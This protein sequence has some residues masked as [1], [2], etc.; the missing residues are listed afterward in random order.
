MDHLPEK[1]FE[2]PAN[3][4]DWAVYYR[5]LQTFR[6][7][8]VTWWRN[9]QRSDGQAGGGW[10]DDT[11]IFSR[12]FGDMPLDSNEDAMILFNK[13]FDGFEKTNYFKDGYC[14]IDPI[15]R[16]HNGDF[17]RERY[18]SLIYNIGDPR[19][20]VWAM[21]EAWHWN[22]PDKTP[23]NYG[24]GKGF[25]FGKD[26]ME[27]YWGGHIADKPYE[28]QDKA[29][30]VATLKKAALANDEVTLWRFTEAWCHSD[31]QSQYGAESLYNMLL[32]G[33]GSAPGRDKPDY[34]NRN[35][36]TVGIGWVKGG[37][38]QLGRLIEYSGDDGL[39]V[40][41]YSFDR[42]DREATA[43][44]YR[45][46]DGSYTV[47]LT[48]D[49]DGD[50]TF[51]KMLSERK[52][53]IRRFDTVSATVPPQ[54]LVRLSIKQIKA[55][56]VPASMPDLAVCGRYLA[57]NRD[58]L[59]AEIYNIGCAPSGKFTVTV[60]CPQGAVLKT[61]TV[62]SIPGSEDFVPKKATV[63]IPGLPPRSAYT[64]KIDSNDKV[65]EIFEGNNAATIMTGTF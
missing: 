32:G 39:V 55:A 13:V 53:D 4:P 50:G 57:L 54:T 36:L 12:T 58:T 41:M 44:L 35:V 65:R 37:G 2:A 17:V 34:A 14:R 49:T 60:V 64:L 18:K 20:A 63:T 16:L 24:D 59:T 29:A 30:L 26:V 19:S 47:T 43:R 22:K 8:I 6:G 11:L 9:H 51:E 38:P 56:K 46:A 23:I 31:D 7:R 62:N 5:E 27:W 3:A 10:N 52:Q 40:D 1:T 61:V 28:L 15:D 48:A 21:E 33:W 45:I 25:L 42:F